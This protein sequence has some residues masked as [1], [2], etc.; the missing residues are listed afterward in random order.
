[1]SD[2]REDFQRSIEEGYRQ[3]WAKR[4]RNRLQYALQALGMIARGILTANGSTMRMGFGLLKREVFGYRR[5][6]YAS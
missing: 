4:K 2:H 6:R 1:M 3:L 5:G